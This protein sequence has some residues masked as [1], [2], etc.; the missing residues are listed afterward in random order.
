MKELKRPSTEGCIG[1]P[2][3]QGGNSQHRGNGLPRCG[4]GEGL[5]P[6]TVTISARATEEGLGHV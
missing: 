5:Q 2:S 6:G 1:S 4:G 3:W